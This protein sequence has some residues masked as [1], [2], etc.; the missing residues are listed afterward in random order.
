M[1]ASG[2]TLNQQLLDLIV[3]EY[4]LLPNSAKALK[5][6]IQLGG[7]DGIGGALG[8]RIPEKAGAPLEVICTVGRVEFVVR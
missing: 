7:I 5:A 3:A 1:P 4:R 6:G 2:K 8:V